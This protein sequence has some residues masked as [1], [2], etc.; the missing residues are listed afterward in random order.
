MY[1]HQQSGEA[2]NAMSLDENSP[3]GNNSGAVHV[4]VG[5]FLYLNIMSNVG[6]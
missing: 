4:D 2:N 3:P 6:V 1:I 5:F